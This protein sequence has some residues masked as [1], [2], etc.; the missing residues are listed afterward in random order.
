MILQSS[1][2]NS[3]PPRDCRHPAPAGLQTYGTMPHA[4]CD[5]KF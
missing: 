4:L 1:Y 2:E 3:P 5:L